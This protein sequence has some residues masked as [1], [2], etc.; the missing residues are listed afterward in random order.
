[1]GEALQAAQRPGRDD[2]LLFATHQPLGQLR[3]IG[4]AD[5]L[6]ATLSTYE[7]GLDK[8]FREGPGRR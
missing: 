3:A 4:I 6:I 5:E 2:E 1:M 7:S 8:S